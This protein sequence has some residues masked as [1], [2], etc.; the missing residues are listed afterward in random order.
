MIKTTQENF[1]MRSFRRIGPHLVTLILAFAYAVSVQGQ[2][3]TGSIRGVVTDP[4]GA[5]VQGARVTITKRSNN[6]STTTQTSG[7]GQF[8][9]NNL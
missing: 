2:I 4:N 7:A 8:E 3:T 9:F 5:V 6:S 1:I